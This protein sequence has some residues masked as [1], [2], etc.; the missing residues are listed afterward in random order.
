MNSS[1]R[2]LIKVGTFLRRD[3]SRNSS[4]GVLS[5]NNRCISHF[6]TFDVHDR[7]KTISTLNVRSETTPLQ[8]T[9][10]FISSPNPLNRPLSVLDTTS[11][12]DENKVNPD[13]NN[14]LGPDDAVVSSLE[15]HPIQEKIPSIDPI[16][17]D[18]APKISRTDKSKELGKDP[19]REF[20]KDLPRQTRR[21]SLSLSVKTASSLNLG[22]DTPPT[23]GAVKFYKLRHRSPISSRSF[24]SNVFSN[25]PQLSLADSNQTNTGTTASEVL[26]LRQ[27]E[28]VKW[29]E[30]EI[31]KVELFYKAKEDE[32]GVLLDTLREQLL[33]MR[34]RRVE[35]LA[36]AKQARESQK[37]STGL[38]DT[39]KYSNSEEIT[40][41]N[42]GNRLKKYFLPAQK[43]VINYWSRLSSSFVGEN[44]RAL[45]NLHAN[46]GSD[47]KRAAI[48]T[49][50][51]IKTE[52][53]DD[54]V[55]RAQYADQVP[56]RKAKQKLKI[57]LF[58][59]FRG[60]E[61]LKSYTLLNQLAFRK[62][63]KNYNQAV[64]TNAPTIN[65]S[66]KISQAWFVKSDV[67]DDYLS[68]A[69]T[70]YAHYFECGNQKIAHV[71]LRGSIAPRA[72]E[73]AISF[74][75][76][77][78]I[79]IGIVLCIQGLLKGIK[80]LDSPDPVIRIQTNFLL[81]LYTG[82][83][84]ALYLFAFF[85][86]DCYIWTKNNINYQF[87]FE[88]DIGHTLDWRKLAS[89]PSFLLTF[90]GLCM[91][92]NFCLSEASKMYIYIPVILIA[93]TV[94][95]VFLPA[96]ILFHRGRR[97]FLYANVS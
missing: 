6:S 50:K 51:P 38:N 3:N 83:F 42:T 47:S 59:C 88:F 21:K 45:Q 2:P 67:L 17:R 91:W 79:G 44:T 16:T 10:Q 57:A 89:V 14:K 25:G 9:H 11:V 1:T 53:E 80:L 81:Q 87:V 95:L 27:F 49:I 84:L 73:S 5:P 4:G 96:P 33:E 97:W 60:I 31:E 41:L 40:E 8:D 54:H 85:C 24:L 7:K 61:L 71:K 20:H 18:F 36:E 48:T 19:S 52:K 15:I 86:F 69:V 63:V 64:G 29:F 43:F 92:I 70:L 66:G 39:V 37:L 22:N 32:A 35:E 30:Q 26:R 72:D 65:L 75:N 74:R 23:D 76:G 46:P 62:M 28:F 55:R 94:L 77:V 56:Y 82:Y 34:S 90:L 58:Q 12:K 93:A 68:S 78:A 13:S